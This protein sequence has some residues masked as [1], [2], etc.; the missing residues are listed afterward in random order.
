MKTI[1]IVLS[2][3]AALSAA[4]LV[5]GFALDGAAVFSIL[6]ASV[7]V[8]MFA[9][10]YSRTPTYHLA[11]ARRKA[12]VQSASAGTEFATMTAASNSTLS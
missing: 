7:V 11:P 6:V 3:A 5:A 4:V 8:G 12:K 2:S 10:D 9:S 1:V